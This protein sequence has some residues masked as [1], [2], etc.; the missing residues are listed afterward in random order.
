MVDVV[1]DQKDNPVWG[2][3]VFD[4]AFARSVPI[5]LSM[6]VYG[7]PDLVWAISERPRMVQWGYTCVATHEGSEAE[8]LCWNLKTAKHKQSNNIKVPQRRCGSL[9]NRPGYDG[10]RNYAQILP[11]PLSFWPLL[12]IYFALFIRLA[13]F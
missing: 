1:F 8:S 7:S 6:C 10:T 2:D 13:F 11:N 5:Y 9:F 3:S 12:F 4:L